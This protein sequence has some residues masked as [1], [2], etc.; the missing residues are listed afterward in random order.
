MVLLVPRVE[1]LQFLDFLLHNF[2]SFGR[3]VLLLELEKQL[4]NFVH[5]VTVV[6]IELVALGSL[7]LFVRNNLVIVVVLYFLENVPYGVSS[8]LLVQAVVGVGALHQLVD[9]LHFLRQN[10]FESGKSL[11][12]V[13]DLQHFLSLFSVFVPDHESNEEEQHHWL[14][15]RLVD[16]NGVVHQHPALGLREGRVHLHQFEAILFELVELFV[17]VGVFWQKLVLLQV[18]EEGDF[19]NFDDL[20]V[21]RDDYL[22]DAESL[23]GLHAELGV[24]LHQVGN[25]LLLVDYLHDYSH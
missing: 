8:L 10:L 18:I 11:I 6:Y 2:A 12:E 7:A 4:V 19:A 25:D 22:V 21:G 13:V 1:V 24:V 3:Q 23:H 5:I 14:V 16:L 17:S 15:A 20:V 9:A